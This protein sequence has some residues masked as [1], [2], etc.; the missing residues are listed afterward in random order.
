M[1]YVIVVAVLMV[2]SVCA[3]GEISI[4]KDKNGPVTITNMPFPDQHDQKAAAVIEYEE[5]T[6]QERLQIEEEKKAQAKAWRKRQAR[7]ERELKARMEA[8][9]KAE[10]QQDRAAEIRRLKKEVAEAKE[11]AAAAA[12]KASQALDDAAAG[13]YRRS[14]GTVDKRFPKHKRIQTKSKKGG[15]PHGPRKPVPRRPSPGD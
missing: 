11:A 12:V 3:A 5:L 1:R 10:E 13:A 15:D 2:A 8:E 9:R 4:Y 14:P 7:E 6:D